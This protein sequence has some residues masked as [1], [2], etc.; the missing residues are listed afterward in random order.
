MSYKQ[1]TMNF[2][3]IEWATYIERFNR[4]PELDG[5]QRVRRQGYDR[6]RDMLA[7]ILAW[8]EDVMPAILAIA[9]NREF[10]R[11]KYDYDAFNAE[12]VAKYKDWDETEFL[13]HFEKTRQ[14]A[15]ADLRSVNEAAFDDKRI[16]G[17]INGIFIHH[18]RE[19]L[20]AL[21]KFL[22]LDTLEHEWGTYIAGFD[23]YEKKEEFLK[24]Q[25]VERFGDLLVHAVAWW[26]EGAKAVQ[27]ALKDPA[28]TYAGPGDTDS[29]N[30]EIVAKN[31]GASEEELRA[32]FEQKRLEMIELVRSL[33]DS[34]F[35]NPTI[36]EWLAADVVEHYDEHTF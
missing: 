23:A 8:W 12:A 9:E 29:F 11:K 26:D 33:P 31:R 6:F 5:S 4:L 10:E 16:R 27:G 18:A 25:G 22:T 30:A 24:K 34:A 21:S 14:K 19:H 13:A 2:L 17:R 15:A 36:E 28:F 35:Q 7:H 1:R 3:E 20:V 32:L